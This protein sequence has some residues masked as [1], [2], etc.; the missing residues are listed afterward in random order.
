[1]LDAK[2]HK[3]VCQVDLWMQ[4]EQFRKEDKARVA[5]LRL[6]VIVRNKQLMRSELA[7]YDDMDAKMFSRYQVDTDAIVNNAQKELIEKKNSQPAVLQEFVRDV[8]ARPSDLLDILRHKAFAFYDKYQDDSMVYQFM[9]T[10][11]SLSM[12]LDTVK[13]SCLHVLKECKDDQRRSFNR[14]RKEADMEEALG[15]RIQ[16]SG[17]MD[18]LLDSLE[19]Q[20]KIVS[21]INAQDNRTIKLNREIDGRITDFLAANTLPGGCSLDVL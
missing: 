19:T 6:D 13:T 9:H 18:L 14:V 16:V 15:N 1:M 21:D 4:S 20:D 2:S 11:E 5:A 8:K 7:V 12:C 3:A 10:A 17:V